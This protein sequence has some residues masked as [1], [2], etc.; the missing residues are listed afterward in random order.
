MVNNTQFKYCHLNVGYKSLE[1]YPGYD[2]SNGAFRKH[3]KGQ[4][5]HKYMYTEIYIFVLH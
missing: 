5:E 3:N 4:N 1:N 2:F